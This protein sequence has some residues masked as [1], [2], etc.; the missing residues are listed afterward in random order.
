MEFLSKQFNE[1]DGSDINLVIQ[2]PASQANGYNAVFTP[3]FALPHLP[4][5]PDDAFHEYRFDWSPYQVAFY[6]DNQLL[7]VMTEDIPDAGGHMVFNHWSN[8]DPGWSAGP[9]AQDTYIT[10]S[11]AH[12]YFNSSNAKARQSSAKLC[13]SFNATQVC[14]INDNTT[15]ALMPPLGSA[16]SSVPIP[17]SSASSSAFPTSSSKPSNPPNM[18]AYDSAKR[19]TTTIYI[20]IGV[21]V[22]VVIIGFVVCMMTIRHWVALRNKVSRKMGFR[23]DEGH[24]TGELKSGMLGTVTPT[25]TDEIESKSSGRL[26]KSRN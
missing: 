2:S 1:T 23:S 15:V 18:S 7:R 19:L 22:G 6:A 16:G 14:V 17:S 10:I 13:P 9:P 5:R 25:R 4:F 12:F 24:E 11:H 20:I 8:G 3:G 26:R 21:V